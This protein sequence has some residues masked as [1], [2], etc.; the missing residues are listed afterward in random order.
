MPLT[1]LRQGAAFRLGYLPVL[2][3][4]RGIAVVLVVV[5]HLGQ[6]LWPDARGWLAPGGF[7]GVDLFFA[8]SGFL[9]TCLLIGELERRSRIDLRSFVWRRVLR[10]SP[11]LAAVVGVLWLGSAAGWIPN[12]PLVQAKRSVWT[13]LYIQTWNPRDHALH[14]ELAQTWSLAVEMHAGGAVLFVAVTRGLRLAGGQHPLVLFA[15]TPNRIDG[16]FVGCLGGVAYASG[17]LAGLPRR[18]TTGLTVAALAAL[19]AVVATSDAFSDWFYLGGFTL[20]AALGTVVVV[21]AAR[22][23]EGAVV[24]ALRWGPLPALGR[25]SYSLF[26]WHMPV[27]VV[28]DREA[29]TWPVPLRAAVALAITAALA[30]ASYHWVEVPVLRLRRA[31]RSTV[32]GTTA[33]PARPPG[34]VPRPAEVPQPG[35]IEPTSV[36]ATA[37][38]SLPADAPAYELGTSS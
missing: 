9:I 17:W 19:A 26:L 11:A 12:D 38:A 29:P 2:D 35:D 1:S 24:S 14:P 23:G 37:P 4:I 33:E 34:E 31:A 20:A 16:P 15:D 18:W 8:L 36:T 10:L 27:F 25:A 32:D 22:L 28:L 6:L 21:G 13:L 7:L 30:A 5:Y 3:G